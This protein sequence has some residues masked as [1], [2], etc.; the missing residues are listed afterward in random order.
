MAR[1]WPAR[2]VKSPSERGLE[3]RTDC[4]AAHDACLVHVQPGDGVRERAA[5]VLGEHF[6]ILRLIGGV[7][8]GLEN[9]DE[10]ANRH[11]LLEQTLK[12]AMQHAERELARH[13]VV[14]ERRVRLLE[15]V[16]HLLHVLAAEQIGG[17][18]LE[19]LHQMRRDDRRRL[20]DDVAER[21]RLDAP[22]ARDPAR[23]HAEARID[24]VDA[25]D[26][27]DDTRPCRA[28]EG[29]AA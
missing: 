4:D 16:D 8:D 23:R 20:D 13:D 15:R 19:L 5:R 11:A 27:P 22:V 14:D 12:H 7:G 1:F 2:G 21:L 25:F 28:P 10:V 24:R 29:S 9:R 18:G 3:L 6:R 17:A 26:G